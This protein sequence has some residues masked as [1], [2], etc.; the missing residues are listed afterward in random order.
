[1][2]GPSETPYTPD[3]YR[4]IQASARRSAAVIVPLVMELAAPQSV[5]DVGC[6][7]GTWLAAF[8]EHGVD[9]VLGVDSDSVDPTM[10]EIPTERFQVA[11]LGSPLEIGRQ[12]DLV[13]S[14]EVAEHL[15][16]A[17]ADGFVESLTRLGSLILFSAAIPHQGGAGHLNEQWPAY[18]S[19]RFEDRG[20]EP[21]DYLRQRVWDDD[22]VE[23][24]YAQNM[25]VFATPA[26]LEQRMALAHH[27]TSR[28]PAP[29][30][31][32]AK[33][34]LLVEWAASLKEAQ[35]GSP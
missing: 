35:H 14:L 5:V 34:R 7:A 3:Y 12:F 31:H 20:F 32:P 33:Y 25:L 29:L 30:V 2:N 23:W 24:W 28:P 9:D 18:W 27:R 22:R 21:V 1:M 26:E 11:D 17:S 19:R 4:A 6:G 16:P 8:A 13:V 10:L 15:P